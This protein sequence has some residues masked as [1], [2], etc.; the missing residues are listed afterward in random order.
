MLLRPQ[1][2]KVRKLEDSY[3]EHKKDLLDMLNR[4]KEEYTCFSMSNVDLEY[5]TRLIEEDL[6]DKSSL[7]EGGI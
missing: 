2:P 7:T 6:A 3:R 4:S 1:N 5:I